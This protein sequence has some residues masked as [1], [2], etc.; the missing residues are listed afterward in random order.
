M[1]WVVSEPPNRRT[2]NALD[3]GKPVGYYAPTNRIPVPKGHTPRVTPHIQRRPIQLAVLLV[4]TGVPAIAT[5]GMLNEAARYR[6][7]GYQL[8]QRGDYAGAITQYQKAAQI[9]AS[10]PAPHNDLGIV[11]EAQ[12]QLDHAEQEYLKALSLDGRY[13]GVLSNLALLYEKKGERVKASYYWLQRAKFG[14]P[15]DPWTVRAQERLVEL[16]AVQNLDQASALV[17][18]ERRRLSRVLEETYA[19]AKA[20]MQDGRYGAAIDGFNEVIALERTA[21]HQVYTPMASRMMSEATEGMRASEST[22]LG[23]AR[24]AQSHV[25]D[26]TYAQAKDAFL[27]GRFTEAI[28]GFERVIALEKDFQH[29]TY[30]PF[31]KDYIAQIKQA[32]TRAETRAIPENAQ[33]VAHQ[34]G[35]HGRRDLVQEQMQRNDETLRDFRALTDQRGSWPSPR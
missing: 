35:V 33:T 12:G 31:A 32:V 25:V 7:E 1:R 21:E 29:P 19:Q 20:A 17:Q 2:E 15:G 9:D 3:V 16:G 24:E 22:Q 6:K 27:A 30:T 10:S 11:Y 14:D 8:Q 13:V 23:R 34:Q 5:A 4:L 26:A 28:V 18:E